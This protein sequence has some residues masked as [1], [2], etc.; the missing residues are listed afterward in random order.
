[1]VSAAQAQNSLCGISNRCIQPGEKINFK[2]YYNLSALWIA[3]GEANFT[4][5]MQQVNGQNL[6]HI[7]GEGHTYSSYDWI[8]RVRDKYQTYLDASTLLPVKFLRDVDEG[9][10]IITNRV[11][12]DQKNRKAYSNNKIFSV[13]ECVQD[14]LSAIY[15]ARNIDYNQYK[16]GAK[17]PFK[18]FLDDEVYSLYIRYLGKER[19]VTKYGTFNAIKLAPLLIK[20]TLFKGGEEMEI[21]V[22]DDQNHLPLRINSPILVGSVKVDM[23]GY[24]HLKFPLS[25]LI[26]RS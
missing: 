22:S 19:I 4:T 21:W 5:S 8:F 24:Q 13:P 3:A 23:M 10:Y 14:I 1:M 12:F 15:Y 2:V 17:I 11:R 18:L 26:R 9:G 6:Y 7:V 16:P 25:S 20:G